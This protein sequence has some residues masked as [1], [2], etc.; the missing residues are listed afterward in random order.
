MDDQEGKRNA[1][2]GY[3]FFRSIKYF[4]DKIGNLH[5]KLRLPGFGIH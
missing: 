2:E 5:K 4:Y 1:W 3:R